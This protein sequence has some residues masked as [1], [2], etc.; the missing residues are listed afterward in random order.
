MKLAFQCYPEILRKCFIINTGSFF[1][2][3][4]SIIKTNF[5]K[6]TLKKVTLLGKDY[7]SHL[8]QYIDENNLPKI[9][10]GKCD[11]PMW[12]NPG[13]WKKSMEEASKLRQMEP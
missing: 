6:N 4:W 1:H 2:K 5:K 3:A 12:S 7:Q 8:K 11:V 13:P 9:L 10:G